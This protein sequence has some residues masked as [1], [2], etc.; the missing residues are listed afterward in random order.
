MRVVI[1]GLGWWMI[2]S[3]VAI[4]ILE[5]NAILGLVAAGVAGI[6]LGLLL[7]MK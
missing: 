6:V 3:A 5:S 2:A 4:V 7:F 1:R